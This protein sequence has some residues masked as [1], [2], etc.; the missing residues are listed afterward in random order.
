MKGR[1]GCGE[2]TQGTDALCRAALGGK[3]ARRDGSGLSQAS[4]AG[5]EL[6]LHLFLHHFPV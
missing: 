1:R 4:S 5:F 6:S 2:S 3:A